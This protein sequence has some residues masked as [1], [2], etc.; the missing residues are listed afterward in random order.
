MLT[1]LLGLLGA[2]T[3]GAADFLGGLAARRSSTILVTA[4]VAIVGLVGIA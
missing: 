1:V 4:G 2:L 3:Y